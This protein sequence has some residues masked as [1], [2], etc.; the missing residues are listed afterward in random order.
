[1]CSANTI[2]QSW[3]GSLFWVCITICYV[4]N[5]VIKPDYKYYHIIYCHACRR[6]TFLTFV[7][8]HFKVCLFYSIQ[9]HA[10]IDINTMPTDYYCVKSKMCRRSL[11]IW[12]VYTHCYIDCGELHGD[13][14]SSPFP[15]RTQCFVL[16]TAATAVILLKLSLL[17]RLPRFYRDNQCWFL[18]SLFH[19]SRY[20]A[21]EVRTRNPFPRF[22]PR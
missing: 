3:R 5:D 2:W 6:V 21:V 14:K 13:K 11:S 17:P 19:Y 4:L 9:L 18:N 10:K 16:I 1:M 15:P 22:L 7:F 8:S 20:T 12:I